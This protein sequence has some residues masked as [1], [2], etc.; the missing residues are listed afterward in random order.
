MAAP[1]KSPDATVAIVRKIM[2]AF[3]IVVTVGRRSGWKYSERP[4]PS[5]RYSERH[6]F[7]LVAW[8]F[9]DAYA[10]SALTTLRNLGTMLPKTR[11]PTRPGKLAS[12]NDVW[13]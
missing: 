7:A 6:G 9:G 12:A 3:G 1:L 10:V 4:V 2:K 5:W 8:I 11:T 13:N